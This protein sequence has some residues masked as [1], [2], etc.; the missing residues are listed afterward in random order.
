[1]TVTAQV[2]VIDLTTNPAH[3]DADMLPRSGRALGCRTCGHTA[4][5]HGR[6]WMHRFVRPTLPTTMSYLDDITAAATIELRRSAA[7]RIR[8]TV[9]QL[10]AA[11]IAPNPERLM[12]L[13]GADGHCFLLH[14]N[15]IVSCID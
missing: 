2:D 11:L 9:A 1:M 6:H 8:V 14:P 4:P 15:T 3:L 7:E 12:W 5:E 13:R 10:D